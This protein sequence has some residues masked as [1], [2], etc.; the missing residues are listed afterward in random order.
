MDKNFAIGT[1]VAAVAF[2]VLG[3]LGS[4]VNFGEQVA[5]NAGGL[6]GVLF[7]GAFLTLV[8]GW[9]GVGSAQDG[10]KVGALVGA[11]MSLGGMGAE[12]GAAV[13]PAVEALVHTG[14]V[15]GVLGVVAS[16]SAGSG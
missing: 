9:R 4:Q 3:W 16:R 11:L 8:F 1:I 13:M 6:I 12:I 7:Q 14:I 2:V 10:A 5:M 15:G